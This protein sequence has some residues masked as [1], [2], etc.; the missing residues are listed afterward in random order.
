MLENVEKNKKMASRIKVWDIDRLTPYSKNSRTHSNEQIEQIANSIREFGFNNPILVDSNDGIIAGHGRYLAAQRLHMRHVPVI[1]LDHLTDEQKKAYIIAD[2]Q[3]ALN[4]GWDTDVLKAEI[5]DLQNFEFN[6]DLLG[7][8]D[9]ELQALGLDDESL[10]A[11]SAHEN[12]N[13]LNE[14]QGVRLCVDCQKKV[15]LMSEAQKRKVICL[16]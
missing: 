1:V 15:Q 8:S 9:D 16:D 7:F 11:T 3:I 6:I 10:G 13:L 14:K 2:N 5:Q 12:E 4:A